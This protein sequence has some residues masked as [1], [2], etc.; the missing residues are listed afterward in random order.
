[1]ISVI[2]PIHN[3]EATIARCLDSIKAQL[4]SDY[5][6][7]MIDDGSSDNSYEICKEYEE[8]YKRFR[9]FA[10]SN[11]GVSW[12]RNQGIK[13]SK[14]EYIMFVDSDDTINHHMLTDMIEHSSN[15]EIVISGIN[16]YSNTLRKTIKK[17]REKEGMYS[18]DEYIN[19]LSEGKMNP[20]FGGPYGKLFDSSIIKS[21]NILFNEG[22]TLA[23]DFCFNLDVLHYVNKAY[24]INDCLYNY[25][26]EGSATTLTS[27]NYNKLSN[28]NFWEQET[29]TYRKYWGLLNDCNLYHRDIIKYQL[30][31][32]YISKVNQNTND[33]LIKRYREIISKWQSHKGISQIRSIENLAIKQ[34]MI[35]LVITSRF[36]IFIICIILGNRYKHHNAKRKAI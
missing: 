5:E 35:A 26:V 2:I 33:S 36:G 20:F 4:Y 12:A 14:G 9:L 1:M 19:M 6:V 22:Q 21:H 7:L 18:I 24:L 31:T 8:K 23:E 32:M 11:H 3:S 34:K 27:Y 15:A 29:L 17:F 25:Y 28:E 13:L 16:M 10:Y 30:W